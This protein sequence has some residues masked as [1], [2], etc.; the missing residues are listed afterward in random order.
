M[1]VR[2]N[3]P[4]ECVEWR[5]LELNTENTNNNRSFANLNKIVAMFGSDVNYL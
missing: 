5:M 3:Y 1:C 4:V 2:V